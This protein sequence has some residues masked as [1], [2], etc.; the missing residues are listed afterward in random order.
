MEKQ[1]SLTC[2]LKSKKLIIIRGVW[3]SKIKGV[4]RSTLKNNLVMQLHMYVT[5]LIEIEKNCLGFVAEI[6]SI[7]SNVVLL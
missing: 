4:N 5:K 7:G 6:S 2:N 1:N 3:G